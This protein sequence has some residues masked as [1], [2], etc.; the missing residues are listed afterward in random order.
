MGTLIATGG[1]LDKAATAAAVEGIVTSNPK[2]LATGGTVARTAKALDLM[3]NINAV[4][5]SL[6]GAADRVGH[7]SK[8]I[9]WIDQTLRL[10][11]DFGSDANSTSGQGSIETQRKKDA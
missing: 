5:K 9:Y 10:P 1:N 4:G 2:D 8:I 6:S 11:V 7:G 3:Q